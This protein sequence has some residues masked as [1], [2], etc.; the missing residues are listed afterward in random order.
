M[1]RSRS[2]R[3]TAPAAIPIVAV[4][5]LPVVK[6]PFADTDPVHLTGGGL[7]WVTSRSATG[8]GAPPGTG[9]SR[10]LP[11][12]PDITG[13]VMTVLSPRRTA[14]GASV[15]NVFTLAR[16][17]VTVP[18]LSVFIVSL[19][20]AASTIVP[21]RRSPLRN[22]TSSADAT[23]VTASEN[24]SPATIDITRQARPMEASRPE[25]SV[26]AGR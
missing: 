25:R 6:S 2:P 9:T 8:C 3:L 14:T 7:I 5:E 24:P 10:M 12:G 21:V 19:P 26:H 18:A 1:I 4:S 11:A 13:D 16:S 15:A 17:I 22:T 20:W 23:L